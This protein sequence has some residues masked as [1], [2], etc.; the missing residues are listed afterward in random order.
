LR[1]EQ[2][3]NTGDTCSTGTNANVRFTF[4]VTMRTSPTASL[5]TAGS[6]IV[7]NG[8]SANYTASSVSIVSQNISPSAGRVNLG[9]FP[10]FGSNFF[11]S[12]S[13]AVGTAVMFMS[14]EL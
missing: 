4:P 9:G 12:G 7:G 13:D 1:V 6:W 8:F 10:S 5:T 2:Q 3:Q 11:V 14:A